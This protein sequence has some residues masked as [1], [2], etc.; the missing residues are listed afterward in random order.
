M[1][2]NPRAVAAQ[3][4]LSRL[5]LTSGDSAAALRLAEE[6]RQTQPSSLD[7][8]LALARSLVVAGN[9]ARADTEVAYLLKNAPNA[10][11]VHAVNGMH[12]A[13]KNNPA[14]ARKAYL[15]ALELSP[16][17]LEAIGGLTYLDLAAKD[18]ASAIA[19]LD[20]EIAKQPT[21]AAL[22]VLLA[23]AH[24]VAGDQAKEEQALRRAISVD[25]RLSVAYERL[26]GFTSG[27]TVSMKR[28]PNTK[29]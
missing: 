3:V 29:R 11:A 7:A 9:T 13:G 26:A 2:L 8:R 5:S 10:A 12:E 19:R 6:A 25:P 15:R 17:F 23:R 14:A 4:E 18:P 20:A 21:K 24:A 27:T 16:G 28:A 1:R 22:F